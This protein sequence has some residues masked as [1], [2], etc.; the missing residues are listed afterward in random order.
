VLFIIRVTVMAL[1][2]GGLTRRRLT[3]AATFY[4]I[5]FLPT[6][7]AAQLNFMA[8]ALVYARLY[9]PVLSFLAVVALLTAALPWRGGER[10][11][12]A[13]RESW[14]GGLRLGILL[15]Y[16]AVLLALGGGAH[17]WPRLTALF[18]VLSAAATGAAVTFLRR[19]PWPDGPLKLATA[20]AAFVVAA[21]VFVVT[22]EYEAGPPPDRRDGSLMVMSGINSASGRGAVFELD[23]AL[24]GYDCAQVYHFSYAGP[25]DGQPRRNSTCPITTGAPFEPAHTRRPMAEQAMAFAQQVKDVP[26]PLTVLTHSH[27]VWVAWMAIADGLAPEVD[28]LILIG[29]FQESVQGYPD[30][31]ESGPSEVAGDLL[32]L[33][34][35]VGEALGFDYDP[36]D[37]ASIETLGDA[38][39]PTAIIGRPLPAGVRS[40]A[41]TS[42]T[43]LP[44]MPSGWRLAV[45]HNACPVREAHPYLP[46]APATVDEANRFL[47]GRPPPPCPVWRDWGAAVTRGFAAPPER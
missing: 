12:P 36:D 1:L 15:P 10:L 4:G 42:A 46:D 38:S 33:L 34:V 39:A 45:D 16:A 13:W 2:L 32:R 43:D 3:F 6:L 9:W 37:P 25:G 21:T 35:P 26:R 30:A 5:L 31:G 47:D 14:K 17:N 44:L 29:P 18:V 40:I 7:L 8:F 24:Y 20:A 22:R 41:I 23:P 27:S 19:P 11:R 28:R